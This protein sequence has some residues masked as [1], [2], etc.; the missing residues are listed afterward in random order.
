MKA[1]HAYDIRGVYNSDLNRDDVAAIGYHLPEVLK[2]KKILVGRDCRLSSPEIFEALSAGIRRGGGDVF[3]AGLTTTPMVY[4][5]T[6]KFS[7]DASVMITASHNPKNYNGL[8]VSGKGAAPVGYDNGLNILE[9]KLASDRTRQELPLK[10]D[11]HTFDIKKDYLAFL[12]PYVPELAG[13]QIAIDCSNGMAGLLIEDLI[14]SGPIYLNKNPDGNFPGHDP[15]PLN[16][17]NIHDLVEAVRNNALDMGIIFDGDADRVMFVDDQARFVSP[18]L[19]IALLGH[20][21]F[22]DDKKGQLVL[23]DIRSSKSVARYL[24]QFGADVYTWKVGRAF[25]ARKLKEINGL[26]GGELAGHYY[27]RDFYY[28]DSGMLACLL[29]LQVV[30]DFKKKGIAFSRILD[31]I[32][33]FESS[34]ERNYTI[35]HKAEAMS[36]VKHHFEEQEKPLAFFDFDGYRME[37]N[38][39]WFNIRPSNT[40]PYLRL[41]V[42]ANTFGTLVEKVQEIESVLK[43]FE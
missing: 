13:M 15:N 35:S 5:A 37:Y 11:V 28:S 41:I 39:W 38:D 20:Y 12:S 24:E 1:F 36:A 42:E 7:F 3:D 29:V 6:A 40:E 33:C 19:V 8:K 9:N 25:A 30:S 4:W 17:A 16:P 43:Q 34:G 31:K 18:D 26:Y 2:A 14:G 27:F 23:Q 21:F 32:K 22:S 10:G